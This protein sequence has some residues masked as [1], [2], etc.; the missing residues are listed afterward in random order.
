MATRGFPAA[1]TN[2]YEAISLVDIALG[3]TFHDNEGN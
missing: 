2:K 3:L 1:I